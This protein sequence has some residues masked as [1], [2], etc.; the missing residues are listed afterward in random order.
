MKNDIFTTIG[1]SNHALGERHPE[2]YYA[3]DPKAVKQ[4]LKLE[5][6]GEWI[7]EPACGEGHISEVLKKAGYKVYST[8]L[9]N[10]GY[11]ED[12]FDF[13]SLKEP[14]KM[15][16][17]TNPPYKIATEFTFHTLKRKNKDG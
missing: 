12:F 17:I 2:D 1:A 10:R 16:I 5:Q 14:I 13:F 3:T 8:D 4:L 11:G 9:I 6:F 15:D 7:Y